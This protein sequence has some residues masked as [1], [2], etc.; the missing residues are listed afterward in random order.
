M[1]PSIAISP[2]ASDTGLLIAGEVISAVTGIGIVGGALVGI[3]IGGN[4]HWL[5]GALVG[6]VG[7][8]FAGRYEDQRLAA[9]PAKTAPL[10]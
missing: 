4:K 2:K 9:A 3:M 5:T 8:F 6:V 7:G 1:N 10:V